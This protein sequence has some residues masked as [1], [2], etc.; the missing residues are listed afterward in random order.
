MADGSISTAGMP[1]TAGGPPRVTA[2]VVTY[3]RRDLLAEALPAVLAQSRAPDAV[4]VIDNASTDG[5]TEMIRARF[6][7]VRLATARRN[8]G[9]A[10]GFA[11]GL[12]LALAGAADLVW[13]M[14]DDTVPEPGALRAM[15]DAR[16]LHPGT[17]P[18]LIASR[19]V[20][21]DGR[22]HPMNTPRIKPFVSKEE[23]A[24][25][26]TAGCLPIRS[27]SFVSI[28]VDAG[29][30][31]ARGLPQADYFLWNDDF[32]FTARLLRG[33]AGLLCPASVVVHKTA[34]FGST[35][36]DPGQRFFYEVRNKIWTLRAGSSLAPAERVLYGGAT[37]RRWA[38]TFA[39]SSDR[40]TLWSCLLSGLAA[41]TRT[42]PRPTEEVLESA[43]LTVPA[44]DVPAGDVL[45]GGAPG[46]GAPAGQV[47]GGPAQAPA[48]PGSPPG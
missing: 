15:L 38:R 40:G 24:A 46:G 14:D 6:P 3:N 47:P 19:V 31:R 21:T 42:S 29:L 35:D 27:A 41:G 18:A 10:G 2:V 20:W 33:Q 16:A 11:Y 48:G 12:A 8:T 32:E 1:A 37:L 28:L 4:L 17:P 43:G 45:G 36:A 26:A 22:P 25:A 9:G 39:K 7:S 5:T 34:T 30:C 23:R 44:G 13:L